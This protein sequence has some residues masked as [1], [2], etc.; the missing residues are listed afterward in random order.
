[1]PGRSFSSSDYRYGFN[2]QEKDDEVSGV[3]NS[4]TAEFWQYSPRLGRRWNID[5]KPNSSISSYATF[6][7]SPIMFVDVLGDTIKF[8]NDFLNDKLLVK[9][10]EKWKQSDSGKDFYKNLVLLHGY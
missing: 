7:N 5:P 9:A 2:G 3:G 8:T 10:H 6:A 1:M 4:Y